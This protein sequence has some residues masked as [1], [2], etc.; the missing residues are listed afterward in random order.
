MPI[1]A[2]KPHHRECLVSTL[3]WDRLAELTDEFGLRLSGSLSSRTPSSG[4]RPDEEGRAGNV[5]AEKVMVRTGCAAPRARRLSAGFPADA[6]AGARRQHRNGQGGHRGRDAGRSKLRGTGR[7][8]E[9]HG[10]RSWSTTS[11]TKATAAPCSI[12]PQG[13][14]GGQARA[15]AVLLRSVGLPGLRT[16][17][18][19]PVYTDRTEIPAAA[20]S[21]E[22]AR[23]SRESG[24]RAERRCAS[25]DGGHFLEDAESANVI[26]SCAAGRNRRRLWSWLVILIPGR[27]NGAV[28]DGGGCIAAWTVLK[29]LKDLDLVQAHD[30]GGPLH[31]RGERHAGRVR[32]SG[33]AQGRTGQPCDDAGVRLRHISSTGFGLSAN[34][35][36]RA[37]VREIAS[38]LD[39]IGV[40]KIEDSA[41]V[42]ISAPVFVPAHPEHVA[43]GG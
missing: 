31:E 38:L 18:P 5:H 17:I 6:D 2:C 12:G 20:I 42:P 35:R 43:R 41:A 34:E 25:E 39:A 1:A 8:G 23:C 13:L 19:G 11:S 4:S 26:G 24:P 14:P 7:C 33:C 28:D 15:R 22:D 32:L 37:T 16:R 3:A 36:A 9:R 27:R 30:P 29:V 10:A 40:S 21:L